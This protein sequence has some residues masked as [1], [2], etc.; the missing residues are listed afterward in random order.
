MTT[1]FRFAACLT[2][3]VALIASRGDATASKQDE[4][5]G[6]SMAVLYTDSS[7]IRLAQDEQSESTKQSPDSSPFLI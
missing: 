6:A 2:S 4:S 7:I 3:L 1:R 5:S